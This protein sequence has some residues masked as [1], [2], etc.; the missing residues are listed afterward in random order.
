MSHKIGTQIDTDCFAAPH[1]K[2]SHIYLT[3][4]T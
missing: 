1:T 2:L 4:V 3:L